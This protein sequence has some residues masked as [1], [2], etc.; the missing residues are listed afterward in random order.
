MAMSRGTSTFVTCFAVFWSTWATAVLLC[1]LCHVLRRGLNRR[2]P[3][4]TETVFLPM[5]ASHPLT[6]VQWHRLEEESGNPPRYEEAI[7]M[8]DLPPLPPLP[9]YGQGY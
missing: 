2:V 7:L 5:A 3:A 6:H 1:W 9:L 4:E 8:E